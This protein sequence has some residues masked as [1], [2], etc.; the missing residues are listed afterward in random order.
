MYE[1]LYSLC[2]ITCIVREAE[3]VRD[4][5]FLEVSA[6]RT[7]FYGIFAPGTIG[8]M[9]LHPTKLEEMARSAVIPTIENGKTPRSRRNEQSIPPPMKNE[10]PKPNEIF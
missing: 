2:G 7:Q 5:R 3:P 10:S 1:K 6:T 4:T 9:G 8:E